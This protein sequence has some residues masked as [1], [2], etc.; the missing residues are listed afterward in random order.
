MTTSI[1]ESYT[2]TTVTLGY[3]AA[4]LGEIGTYT[5]YFQLYDTD[6]GTAVSNVD[7]LKVELTFQVRSST[8]SEIK[9]LDYR[10]EFAMGDINTYGL[11]VAFTDSQT[12]K[13][14]HMP[15]M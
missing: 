12:Q 10:S 2:E 3:D 14:I 11:D 6:T 7:M 5:V 13:P 8:A 4:N 15:Q 1:A 9:Y